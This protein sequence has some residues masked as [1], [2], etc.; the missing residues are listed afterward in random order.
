M[1]RLKLI[2]VSKWDPR[3]LTHKIHPS[4]IGM[5][6][7][8]CCKYF[9]EYWQRYNGTALYPRRVVGIS[10]GRTF[11]EIEIAMKGEQLR[12]PTETPTLKMNITTRQKIRK[13]LVAEACEKLDLN[14][15]KPNRMY[16][17]DEKKIIYCF[18]PKVRMEFGACLYC[19]SRRIY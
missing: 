17:D 14:Y 11:P 5:L 6:W 13:R 16:I 3:L 7:G 2:R 19:N 4:L 18:P 10:D 12:S 9:G 15:S 8:V 1:L